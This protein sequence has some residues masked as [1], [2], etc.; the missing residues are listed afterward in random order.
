MRWRLPSWRWWSRGS[1][2]RWR[3][4]GNRRRRRSRLS[5]GS[6]SWFSSP[7]SCW[8]PW[9]LRLPPLRRRVG[10]LELGYGRIRFFRSRLPFSI[11][12]LNLVLIRA[13]C[14]CTSW[15]AC[16]ACDAF[17]AFIIFFCVLLKLDGKWE[18]LT[19]KKNTIFVPKIIP[20]PSL[21]TPDI[22]HPRWDFLDFFLGEKHFID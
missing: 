14:I 4:K 6:S 1:R 5:R 8:S 22:L 13:L 19:K 17:Q 9:T 11:S 21:Q 7:C 18:R 15:V 10:D 2:R 16:V 12:G 20:W 3:G